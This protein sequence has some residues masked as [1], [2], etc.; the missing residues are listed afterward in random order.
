MS[1]YTIQQDILSIFS[2]IENN[3]GEISKEQE[4][5]LAIKEEEL[6]NKLSDYNKAIKSWTYDIDACK[7]EIKRLQELS[8][9]KSNRIN[10]IK[11]IMKEAIINFGY[12][13][14]NENKF[15]ELQDCKLYTKN[16]T[17]V[18]ID[19]DRTELLKEKF[20]EYCKELSI[21]NIL[22]ID[23][24]ID[25]SGIL[26]AI[27]A[28]CKAEHEEN[29]CE[30]DFIPF[31]EI[32]LESL[33]FNINIIIS[34]DDLLKE[35]KSLCEIIVDNEYPLKVEINNSKT[36]IKNSIINYNNEITFAK[37]KTETSLCMK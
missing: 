21:N 17:S 35:T 20:L 37:L 29:G 33:K 15:I 25:K 8:K 13:S 31:T 9:V 23:P 2:E 30:K 36:D 27:N 12:T 18:D 4:E 5:L 19:I 10:R 14:K 24:Y 3:D 34:P 1:L 11:N 6:C 32:D 22:L 7:C 16:N 26:D 28:I